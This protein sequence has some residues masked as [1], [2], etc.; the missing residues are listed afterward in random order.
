MAFHLCRHIFCFLYVCGGVFVEIYRVASFGASLEFFASIGRLYIY[1]DR[2][3]RRCNMSMHANGQMLFIILLH[4]VV[5]F[6]DLFFF[7]TVKIDRFL[8]K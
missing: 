3:S 1:T 2:V 4:D 7:T 5:T 8:G 6:V